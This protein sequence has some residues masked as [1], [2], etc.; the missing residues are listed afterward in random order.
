MCA[1]V[2][3]AS[4]AEYDFEAEGVRYTVLSALDLTAEVVGFSDTFNYNGILDIP[5]DVEFRGRTLAVLGIAQNAFTDI[6][7]SDPVAFIGKTGWAGICSEKSCS[8]G[9]SRLNTYSEVCP[10]DASTI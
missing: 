3:H 9:N 1:F 8:L 7:D 10:N 5:A 4:E 6:T 2:L